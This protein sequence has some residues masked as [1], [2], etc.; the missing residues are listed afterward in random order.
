MHW[1]VGCEETFNSFKFDACRSQAA[2]GCHH[3]RKGNRKG[4]NALSAVKELVRKEQ[5]DQHHS[6]RVDEHQHR[7]RRDDNRLQTEHADQ[8]RYDR[9]DRD[10]V[11]VGKATRKL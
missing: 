9:E 4:I 2:Q 7:N 5:D 3:E 11:N 6:Q 1:H 10:P 8:E